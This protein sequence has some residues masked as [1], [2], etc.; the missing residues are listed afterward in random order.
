LILRAKDELN[1]S[2]DQSVLVGDKASDI[3][4]AHAASVGLSVLMAPPHVSV[5]PMPD[6]QAATLRQIRQLLFG[7]TGSTP[8]SNR[9]R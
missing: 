7:M 1:L 5:S 6:L 4:A 2:L 3:A 8:V 9:V